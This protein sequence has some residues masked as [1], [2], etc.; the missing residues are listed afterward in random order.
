M[1]LIRLYC[2][3]YPNCSRE[4]RSKYTLEKHIKRF[5]LGL[6]KPK[7]EIC[8]REFSST[9]SFQQH[10]NIHLNIKPFQCGQCDRGFR[11]KCM[12][13]RHIRDHEFRRAFI[14]SGQGNYMRR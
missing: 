10:K 8:G 11:N 12:L 5:H 3:I 13:V 14:E 7:C 2:C 1:H 6:D 4:Y 9:E